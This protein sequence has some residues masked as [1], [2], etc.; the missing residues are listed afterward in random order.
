M[1][2]VG[3]AVRQGQF[4]IPEGNNRMLRGLKLIGLS[5]WGY[6]KNAQDLINPDPSTT[7]AKCTYNPNIECAKGDN[8]PL[9]GDHTHFILIDD[10]S[11]YK[12]FGKYAEF[13]TKFETMLRTEP[14]HGLGIPVVTL[15]LEGGVDAI[16]ILKQRLAEG[17]SAVIIEGS[18][19][20]ADIIAYAYKNAIKTTE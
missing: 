13:I 6:V 11:R 1:K 12:F 10:G 8:T 9:N 17:I 2:L 18:G 14:P 5:N 7:N 19:R 3:D 20:A 15:L 4:Y 16:R